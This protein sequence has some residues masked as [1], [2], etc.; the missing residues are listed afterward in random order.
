[1]LGINKLHDFSTLRH[2]KAG[3][4]GSNTATLSLKD[5]SAQ[6]RSYRIDANSASGDHKS[7]N[8]G[9]SNAT[10]WLWLRCAGE[11][12]GKREGGMTE[13]ER[14]AEQGTR[15]PYISPPPSK[16]DVDQVS[17]DQALIADEWAPTPAPSAKPP[18]T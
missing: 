16:E 5:G 8:G 4:R 2:T 11:S 6:P 3:A 12:K 9:R 10:G 1:L 17:R 18:S 13:K 7:P 14:P 15:K